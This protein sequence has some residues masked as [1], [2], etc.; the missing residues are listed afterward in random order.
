MIDQKGVTNELPLTEGQEQVHIDGNKV[1]NSLTQQ[2]SQ[3]NLQITM[4]SIRNQELMDEI[5]LLK[6]NG[7]DK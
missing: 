6:K 2:I 7:G 3:Q 4:L 1:I 5:A